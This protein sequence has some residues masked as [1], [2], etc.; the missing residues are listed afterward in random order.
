MKSSQSLR[1]TK[2]EVHVKKEELDVLIQLEKE[3]KRENDKQEEISFRLQMAHNNSQNLKNTISGINHEVAPWLGIIRNVSNMMGQYL[4]TIKSTDFEWEFIRE[5]SSEME[6]ASEHCIGIIEN[7]SKS[8]KYLQRYDMT[9]TNLLSTVEAM[10]SVALLNSSI[11]KN[12]R[13]S[14]IHVDFASLDFECRHSPM[15]LQQIILNLVNNSIDHNEHM[16]ENLQIKIYG[17]AKIKT[18]YVEDNGKGMTTETMDKIFTPNFSTKDDATISH[19]LGLSMCMDYAIS[20]KSF[21]DVQ[22]EV[23]QYTRFRIAFEDT[24]FTTERRSQDS[25][26]N[27]YK[28]YKSRIERTKEYNLGTTSKFFSRTVEPDEVSTDF[29]L[30]S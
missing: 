14:Q 20:M 23:G 5:K 1:T 29:P 28:A 22:S 21:I 24:E 3:K 15:F 12:L 16:K 4:E 25:S 17:E 30:N 18:L 7:I 2:Q 13:P 10:V 26:S 9:N 6:K 11:R 8:V 27:I 19:G